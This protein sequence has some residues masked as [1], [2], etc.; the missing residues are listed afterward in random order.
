MKKNSDSIKKVTENDT[1]TK[2]NDKSKVELFHCWTANQ[3]KLRI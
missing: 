1:G 2:K 3:V